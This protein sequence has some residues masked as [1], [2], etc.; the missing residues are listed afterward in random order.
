MRTTL[1]K[2]VVFCFGV[3]AAGTALAEGVGSANRSAP[4]GETRGTTDRWDYSGY[5]YGPKTVQDDTSLRSSAAMRETTG[6]NQL[7]NSSGCDLTKELNT[8]GGGCVP[9]GPD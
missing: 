6:Q 4:N 5:V 8:A 7:P 3:M 2:T 1:L 9:L